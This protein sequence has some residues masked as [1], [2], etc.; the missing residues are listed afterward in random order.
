M[1][2][3]VIHSRRSVIPEATTRPRRKNGPSTRNATPGL[4]PNS[5]HAHNRFHPSFR[6][7][8]EPYCFAFQL[9][10]TS[11]VRSQFASCVREMERP[12]PI[13]WTLD[14]KSKPIGTQI[15]EL[16]CFRFHVNNTVSVTCLFLLREGPGA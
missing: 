2:I 13:F 3:G 4:P 11:Q 10:E 14:N 9:D 7:N 15:V 6:V 8:R 12:L 5:S 16:A 1:G